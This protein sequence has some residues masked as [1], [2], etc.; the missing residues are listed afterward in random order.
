MLLRVVVILNDSDGVFQNIRIGFDQMNVLHNIAD[1]C[2]NIAF[3]E[4]FGLATLESM[5]VGNPVIATKT[6]G[7]TRQV[8]DHRDGTENGVGLEPRV[9]ALVGSQSVPYIYEDYA[10]VHETADA[11]HKLYSMPKEEKVALSNKVRSYVQSE[12]A[13]QNTIDS[14]HDSLL[15]LTNDWQSGIRK[16]PRYDIKEV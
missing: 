14:W 12:F 13:M 10:C 16:V 6:G 7:L 11:I 9:K 3:A 15:Q 4:G 5:K 8:I 1:A 2:I